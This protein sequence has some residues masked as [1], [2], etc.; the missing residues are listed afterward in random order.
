MDKGY[1]G[2]FRL[3]NLIHKK[4][5]FFV[6]RA[7]DNI[8]Y[9]FINYTNVGRTTGVTDDDGIKLKGD[10]TSFWHP[11]ELSMIT[12]EDFNT[13]NVYRFLTNNFE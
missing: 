4:N 9:E 2:F 11:G 3:L 8:L 10:R 12:Y 5:E 6:T 7:K 1:V 13:S